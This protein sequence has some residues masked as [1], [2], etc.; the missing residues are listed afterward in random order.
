M[1]LSFRILMVS[2]RVPKEQKYQQIYTQS[3]ITLPT[4]I[5]H[6]HSFHLPKPQTPNPLTPEYSDS[7]SPALETIAKGTRGNP[8]AISR[9]PSP[10]WWQETVSKVTQSQQ[11]KLNENPFRPRNYASDEEKKP[12]PAP[13]KRN[14]AMTIKVVNNHLRQQTH[15]PW[16]RANDEK[17]EAIAI[18][19]PTQRFKKGN[20]LV[21]DTSTPKLT[22]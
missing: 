10:S 3:F 5:I 2:M 9:N 1:L 17:N 20:S 15:L 22:Y 19:N 16:N 12:S 21:A 7:N 14:I 11:Q 4:L 8:I 6:L 18:P 13:E